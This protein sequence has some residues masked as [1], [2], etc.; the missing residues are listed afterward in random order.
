M[1]LPVDLVSTAATT[2]ASPF[3]RASTISGASNKRSSTI[4]TD[5][6]A[7]P[8]STPPST[9]KV[10]TQMA[11]SSSSSLMDQP[12][13][14]PTT[15][16]KDVTGQL[17]FARQELDMLQNYLSLETS[18][19][20]IHINKESERRVQQFIDIGFPGRMKADLHQTYEQIFI[21]L[22]KTLGHTHIQPG[23]DSA[24]SRLSSYKPN[25]DAS[26]EDVPPL[27]EFFELVH[28]A[29]VIQQMIQL[30]Y[31]EEI[32]GNKSRSII[33]RIILTLLFHI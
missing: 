33:G 8:Q 12:P 19:Q 14:S 5:S 26:N 27:T 18:L 32:V 21:Q 7:T 4:S 29:D 25:I 31:D 15:Y 13:R 20:L 11:R 3:Q 10:S 1:T 28:V 16:G 22:L 2:I 6:M 23:F 9:P 30:Y 17:E 24:A